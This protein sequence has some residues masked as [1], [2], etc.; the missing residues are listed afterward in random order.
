MSAVL[1]PGFRAERHDA[2]R[3]PPASVEAEQSVLGGLMLAPEALAKIPLADDDFYRRDHQLIF[4]AITELDR[5]GQ[6]FDAVT[7]GEW[8]EAQGLAEQVAGGA[9][10]IEL[11]SNTP[12]AANITAYARIVRDKSILRRLI[13]VATGLVNSAFNGDESSALVDSGI[14]ELMALAKQESRHEHTLKDAVNLAFDDMIAANEAGDALRGVTTGFKRPDDRL[15]GFH[16]GDLI[17]IGARP[18][19]GKTALL[20]NMAEAASVAGNGVGFISGEQS[21]MQIASRIIARA[22]G[23]AAERLRSGDIEDSEWAR[24]TETVRGLMA[25]N[26]HILDRSAPTMDEVRRTARKW[27]QEH[28]IGALYVDYAQRIRVPKASNRVEE[29]AEVAR[30]LKEVARD[31]DIPVICLAQVVKNVDTRDDKR[32]G[33]SDLANSDEL[34]READLIAMLYRDE[35]YNEESPFKGV[36]ELNVEK[37]R[38]GPCGAFKLA[39]LAETMRFGDLAEDSF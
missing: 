39:W 21:A 38:H 1:R 11:V 8:F 13:Q 31:L 15:G 16:K 2:I 29:V 30:S 24:L 32:P 35:V 19:M 22:S 18:A 36:A 10:L 37:N 34:V 4:R 7:L 20:V 23:V 33:M 17:V 3:V 6:P 12:S 14:G 26:F 5:K 25:R 28:K 27:K 9:Y